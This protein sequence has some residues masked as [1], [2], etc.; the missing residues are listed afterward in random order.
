[1]C[2]FEALF[3]IDHHGPIPGSFEQV[4]QHHEGKGKII[5]QS[6][7]ETC[8]SGLD[9]L[10]TVNVHPVDFFLYGNVLAVQILVGITTEHIYGKSI[11]LQGFYRVKRELG[12]GNI[13]RIKKLT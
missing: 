5:D 9:I 1:M 6:A 12:G 7:Q 3:G 13:L 11:R 10:Q 2:L 8:P 4:Q